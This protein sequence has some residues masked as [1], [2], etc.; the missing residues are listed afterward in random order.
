[1]ALYYVKQHGR[2]QVADY[3]GLVAAGHLAES[4]RDGSVE[5]F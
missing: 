1:M 4:T 3:D 5:L 2:D